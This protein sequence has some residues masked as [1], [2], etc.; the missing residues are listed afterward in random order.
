MFGT[1]AL[2]LDVLQFGLTSLTIIVF[3]LWVFVPLPK[4]GVLYVD[5][6]RFAQV[7]LTRFSIDLLHYCTVQYHE[8][9]NHFI[10]GLTSSR[11]S[12]GDWIALNLVSRYMTAPRWRIK[13]SL[14]ATLALSQV[15][16]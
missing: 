5:L 7:C 1:K 14:C 2:N 13:N 9:E 10:E 11:W 3:L 16:M 6:R 15:F 8:Q 4:G 12:A